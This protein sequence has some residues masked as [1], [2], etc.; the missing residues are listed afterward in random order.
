[1]HELCPNLVFRVAHFQIEWDLLI[2]CKYFLVMETC[3]GYTFKNDLRPWAIIKFELQNY[4]SNTDFQMFT[5][6]FSQQNYWVCVA[7]KCHWSG[8]HCRWHR[9]PARQT[10]HT[11]TLHR[12]FARLANS[13]FINEMFK[14]NLIVWLHNGLCSFLLDMSGF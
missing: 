10:F 7:P 14:K 13:P 9:K 6:N 11:V 8:V 1:M 4:S 2:T 5:L 3:N 12:F